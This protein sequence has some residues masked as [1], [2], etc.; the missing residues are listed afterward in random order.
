MTELKNRIEI[1]LIAVQF[2]K[3]TGETKVMVIYVEFFDDMSRGICY[4]Y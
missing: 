2:I 3:K 4:G 1:F